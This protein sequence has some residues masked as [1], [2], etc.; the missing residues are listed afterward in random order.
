MRILRAVITTV[1]A[2]IFTTIGYAQE[3]IVADSNADYRQSV[4]GNESGI[5]PGLGVLPHLMLGGRLPSAPYPFQTNKS[6]GTI[7]PMSLLKPLQS[8]ALVDWGQGVAFGSSFY[9]SKPGLGNFRS[10]AIGVTQNFGNFTIS[11]ILSGYKY[12]INRNIYND[13]GFSG[14]VTYRLNKHFSL[15][16]FG[17]YSVNNV[18][19][20]P[21]AMPYMN[22]SCFGGSVRYQSCKAFGMELG[23][24]RVFDPYLNR[25]QT[26]PVVAPTVNIGKCAVGVDLGG[27]IYNIIDNIVNKDRYM[28]P[29]ERPACGFRG[30]GSAR[31]GKVEL[32]PAKALK[33]QN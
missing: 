25:W 12:H 27:A 15:N 5:E 21:A 16:V 32:L 26:L 10:A 11:G 14:Y 19:D 17:N 20:S 23:V 28:N 29:M 33:P 1:L 8:N 6:I 7:E 4:E 13:F 30:N 22:F 3:A 24:R 9:S 31:S 2:L 18:F